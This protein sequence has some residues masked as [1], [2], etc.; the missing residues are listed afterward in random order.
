MKCTRC[1]EIFSYKAYGYTKNPLLCPHCAEM[2]K[3]PLNSVQLR[4]TKPFVEA[5]FGDKLDYDLDTLSFTQTEWYWLSKIVL[6]YWTTRRGEYLQSTNQDRPFYNLLRK[7]RAYKLIRRNGYHYLPT[8]HGFNVFLDRRRLEDPL[9]PLKR[10]DGPMDD[11]IEYEDEEAR[12]GQV[13]PF[14]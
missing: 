6:S 10:V 9:K 1:G 5:E 11:F 4:R 7:L 13:N 3:P 8:R 14:K 2:D 12:Q